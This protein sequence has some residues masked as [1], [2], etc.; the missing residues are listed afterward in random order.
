MAK[1]LLILGVVATHMSMALDGLMPEN[2]FGR[3]LHITEYNTWVLFYM[4][5]FFVITGMCSNFD[6][7]FRQYLLDNLISLKMPVLF[8]VGVMG[9]LCVRPLFG[10]SPFSPYWWFVRMFDS[11]VWFL[12]ALFLSKMIYWAVNRYCISRFQ[13][14][15]AC[16][17]V[18]GVGFAA[19]LMDIGD[20]CWLFH[21]LI[22][23][24][25]LMAGSYIRGHKPSRHLKILSLGIFSAVVILLS[26]VHHKAPYVTQKVS[27]ASW[28]D[29]ILVPV[30]SL[31]GTISFLALCEL[32]NKCPIIEYLGKASLVIYC[33]H[34]PELVG[35]LSNIYPELYTANPALTALC[36]MVRLIV[37]TTFCAIIYFILNR[38]FLRL[39]I[40]KKP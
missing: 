20:F 24:L 27:I 4:P 9:F 28:Y 38:P 12:H 32:V 8:F 37:L 26:V 17:L 30:L 36:F 15:S 25:F 11:G 29:A 35:I 14:S 10:F 1:G 2:V 19:I 5:A 16:L 7:P 3:L 23:N 39:L 13:K 33:L 40:G 34:G 18:Y 6:K 21:A 22:L 31:S